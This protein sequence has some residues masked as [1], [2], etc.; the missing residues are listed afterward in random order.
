MQTFESRVCVVATWLGCAHHPFS[1]KAVADGAVLSCIDPLV[2][3]RTARFTYGIEC[4]THY[5]SYRADHQERGHT[6]YTGLSG[7]IM[8]PNAFSSILT[9]VC[10]SY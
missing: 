6:R 9:K 8:L 7:N 4:N 5:L 10:T 2:T 3:S 1:N